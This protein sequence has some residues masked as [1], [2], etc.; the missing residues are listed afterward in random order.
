M[1]LFFTK[2]IPMARGFTR[3]NSLLEPPASH[4]ARSWAHAVLRTLLWLRSR[5]VPGE[6]TEITSN[7]KICCDIR[8][9]QRVDILWHVKL[10]CPSLMEL[11]R[12]KPQRGP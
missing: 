7:G 2:S 8:K 6:I 10:K 5:A 9:V 12:G 4:P 11:Q 1:L 3:L